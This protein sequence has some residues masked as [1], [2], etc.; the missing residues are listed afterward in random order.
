LTVVRIPSLE[1]RTVV[2]GGARRPYL[3]CAGDSGDAG[4]VVC[5]HGRGINAKRTAWLSR[6]A[7]LAASEGAVV[8]FPQATDENGRAAKMWKR[9]R[10]LPHLAAVIADAREEFGGDARGVCLAGISNGAW[11]A[12]WYAAAHADDVAVLGAVA[13][14]RPPHVQP[15]R[16][17][18]V[19]AFH[20]RRDRTLPYEGGRGEIW[21]DSVPE[22]ARA[23]AVA[24]GIDEEPS[25]LA[26]SPTLTRTSYGDDVRLWT[27]AQA[28]HTWPGDRG[29]GRFFI[30]FFHGRISIELDA[31][32]EI[33]RFYRER[34]A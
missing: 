32:E 2:S 5:L 19:I 11:M 24:D 26:V 23:W 17:V 33:W 15:V 16:P 18:P 34:S 13:G 6:M 9:D 14:L 10:D 8:V 7:R 21:R 4:I 30:Q 31:T 1:T 12:S 20:G 27:F 28:G 25:E 29:D 22:A 3:V